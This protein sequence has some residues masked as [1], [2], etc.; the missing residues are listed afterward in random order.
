MKRSIVTAALLAMIFNGFAQEKN[1]KNETRSHSFKKENIFTG[2]SLI[3]S[4]SNY[5]TVL[6]GSPVIGYSITNWLDAGLQFNYTYS[7]NKHVT[8]YDPYSGVYYLTDDKQ[9]QTT[10]GPGAFLKIYPVKFLFLQAQ[11]E[12][13][14]TAIK[15]YPANNGPVEK[16]KV[17]AP[18][19]LAGAGYCSGR[20]GTGS[21]FYY[22]SIMVDL[23][24]DENSPYT[25]V[26]SAGKVTLL[27]IIRA[28][29][30]IPLFQGKNNR[31]F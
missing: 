24:R 28:G 22:L 11:G 6:G 30:Q 23:A 18:S 20:E 8:Y 4:F 26:N 13:N 17:T 15:F 19:F 9:R 12:F 2:G 31:N 7:S 21:L 3:V 10:L 1:N 5:T 16:Y 29:L 27:P 14:S 25:Q